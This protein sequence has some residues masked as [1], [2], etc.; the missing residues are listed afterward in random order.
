[1]TAKLTNTLPPSFLEGAWAAPG[2]TR[3]RTM[4]GRWAWEEDRG[5]YRLGRLHSD[6]DCNALTLYRLDEVEPVDVLTHP[7]VGEYVLN[8]RTGE[9]VGPPPSCK[10]CAAERKGT[11]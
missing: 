5:R 4:F 9:R 2:S 11:K 1:V 7:A 6:P 10:L 8:R 3:T